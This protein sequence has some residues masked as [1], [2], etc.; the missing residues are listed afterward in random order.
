[1]CAY[2]YPRH[3]PFLLLLLLLEQIQYTERKKNKIF[4]TLF[5][6][7]AKV[8][9]WWWW[10]W[11]NKNS[12]VKL[13]MKAEDV[14]KKGQCQLFSSYY[15]FEWLIKIS[16]AQKKCTT[17]NGMSLKYLK[18]G[19]VEYKNI[20]NTFSDNSVHAFDWHQSGLMVFC[21][22]NCHFYYNSFSFNLF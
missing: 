4:L 17:Q 20:W 13:I 6:A 21:E 10:W 11:K 5:Y 15:C 1:M 7:W 14:N 22:E 18:A 19:A 3:K 9:T 2:T 8:N 16:V 12:S